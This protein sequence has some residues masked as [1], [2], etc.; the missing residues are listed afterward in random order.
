MYSPQMVAELNSLSRDLRTLC[1]RAEVLLKQREKRKLAVTTRRQ[2]KQRKIIVE[3]VSK[4]FGVPPRL[5]YLR[6]QHESVAR[7]RQVCMAIACSDLL[8]HREQTGRLFKRATTTVTKAQIAVQNLAD[9]DARFASTFAAVRDEI[10]ARLAT[11]KNPRPQPDA[12]KF[13]CGGLFPRRLYKQNLIDA[14][15]ASSV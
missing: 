6:D 1:D 9:T 15:G 3:T 7:A 5:I 10:K 2:I 8:L 11:L 12:T 4:K 14:T 13:F